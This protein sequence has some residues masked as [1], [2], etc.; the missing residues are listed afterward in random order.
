MGGIVEPLEG[1]AIKMGSG[2]SANAARGLPAR[3]ALVFWVTL[4][5]DKGGR[6]K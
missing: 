5:K 4:V 1:E 3:I 2:H 6:A